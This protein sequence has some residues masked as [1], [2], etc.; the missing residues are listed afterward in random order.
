MAQTNPAVLGPVEPTVGR[1]CA[2]SLRTRLVGDGCEV[3]NP[4]LAAE[5][6]RYA[7]PPC[8]QCGAMTDEEAATKCLGA[9]AGDE[10]H[11][12]HLWPA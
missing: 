6:A 9:A 5:L 4:E 1:Q 2:C 3:C 11:G 12:N 7:K 10:C 8:Q